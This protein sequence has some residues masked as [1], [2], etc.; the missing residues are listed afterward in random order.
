M[1]KPDPIVLSRDEHVDHIIGYWRQ[2]QADMLTDDVLFDEQ[3]RR[4]AN[5]MAEPQPRPI[6]KA[7]V[8]IFSSYIS[9]ITFGG[10]LLWEMMRP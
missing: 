4:V 1:R 10:L 8:A 5:A 2:R 7:V 3:L 6:D 9:F